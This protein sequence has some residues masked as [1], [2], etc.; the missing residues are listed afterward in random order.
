MRCFITGKLGPPKLTHPK[1][2]GLADV[3]G[4]ASGDVLIGFDKEAFG[5]Y[6]LSQSA[7]A[8]VSESAAF[9]Y[10]SALNA[11]IREHSRRLAGAKVVHWFK[12]TVPKDEDPL[13]WLEQ[14]S[15]QEESDALHLAERLLDSI[16]TGERVD[17]LDNHYYAMTMCGA[18]G[19]VM[20]R[21][22]ME[23]RFEDLLT[24]VLRWFDDLSIV[25]RDGGNLAA[26]PKFLAVLGAAVRDLKDVSA[27]FAAKMWRVA[28]RAEPIPQA[29]LAQVLQ[30]A[31]MDILTN[32]A[33]RHARM[34]L[35]KAYHIR[36]HR[37]GG[38]IMTSEPLK[39][40]LNVEHP[41][42]AYQC[43][44]LMAVLAG[45]QRAALGDVG[46]GLVQRYYAA[47]S[48]TP[49]LVLGRLSRTSQFHLNKLE[50]GLAHWYESRISEIWGRIK[51]AIPKSLNLEEQS[52]FALGYYQQMADLRTRKTD[53][54]PQEKE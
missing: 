34:G 12:K 19:R 42:P 36:K 3:G 15:A 31:R 39:S 53:T 18:A 45:L 46:A 2:K 52:L 43:G 14:G 30:R 8:A 33:P 41:H 26:S 13:D 17:L 44:R 28:V 7:N 35:M 40:Y 29:A 27:P 38:Q 20:V 4:I 9:E 10:A 16:R 1:I 11:L 37:I 25:H 21:D 6:G 51:D 32:E 24:S 47:A 49:A 50:G 5:S 23:G 22:W 48:A 54:K